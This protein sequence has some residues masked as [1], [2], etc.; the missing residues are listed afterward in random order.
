[1]RTHGISRITRAT[2]PWVFA[3]ILWSLVTLPWGMWP[4]ELLPFIAPG[5]VLGLSVAAIAA[6]VGP[7]PHRR[8]AHEGAFSGALVLPPLIAFGIAYAGTHRSISPLVV[9][10]GGAWL[11]LGTGVLIGLLRRAR[12]PH[13]RVK[14]GPLRLW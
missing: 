10:V 14:P 9:F 11:S 2:M 7:P 4:W 3:A 6:I 13:S 12:T 5:T 8:P 1:M